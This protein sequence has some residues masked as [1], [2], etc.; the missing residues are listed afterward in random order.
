MFIVLFI[1]KVHGTNTEVFNTFEEAQEFWD[2][3]ADTE[4]CVYG[5]ME[6]ANGIIWEFDN[7]ED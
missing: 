5:K 2:A 1:D 6:D 4:T 7:S 3:Y